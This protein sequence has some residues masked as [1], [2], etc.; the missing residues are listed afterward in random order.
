M[1]AERVPM[2][3]AAYQRRI[4]TGPCFVCAIVRGDPGYD[5]DY[6]RIVFE[7]D[8]HVAFLDRYPTMY[9]KVLVAPRAHVEHV[10]G[11]LSRAAFLELLGADCYAGPATPIRLPSGSVNWP[12][13]RPCRAR[14]GPMMRFPPRRS[15]SWRAAPTSGTPT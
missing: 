11:D 10:V 14:S 6:E 5:Y 4:R 2:D 13:T 12:T 9:G 3:L 15:A 7:D 1:E 8:H